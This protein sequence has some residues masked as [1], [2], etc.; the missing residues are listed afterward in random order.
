MEGMKEDGKIGRG[1]ISVRTTG[2]LWNKVASYFCDD[3]D[4]K[5]KERISEYDRKIMA[6]LYNINGTINLVRKVEYRVVPFGNINRT[7]AGW[8]YKQVEMWVFF[9]KQLRLTPYVETLEY[10]YY[11]RS[12]KEGG[13]TN[14]CIARITW[15]KVNQKS[16]E[17]R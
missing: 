16:N 1:N 7:T 3:V 4:G 13:K 2:N 6:E 17:T 15:N 8:V 14:Y 9:P 12:R 10:S 11:I 5:T